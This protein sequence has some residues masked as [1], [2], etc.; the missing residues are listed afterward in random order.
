MKRRRLFVIATLLISLILTSCMKGK[1]CAVPP[2][3]GKPLAFIVP[4]HGNVDEIVKS[5]G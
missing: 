1:P 5:K 4:L 3:T 2:D